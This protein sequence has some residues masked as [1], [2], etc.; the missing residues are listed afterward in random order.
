MVK[1]LIVLVSLIS[2]S[3]VFF[4]ASI[5]DA[6]FNDQCFNNML[7]NSIVSSEQLGQDK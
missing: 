2:N 7:T 5:L 6:I 3:Q 1:M 4:T